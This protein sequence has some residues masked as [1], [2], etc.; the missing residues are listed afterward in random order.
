[1]KRYAA[2]ND[3]LNFCHG[4]GGERKRCAAKT[5][6]TDDLRYSR[7][8]NVPPDGQRPS[9]R[10]RWKQR[11]QKV[12]EPSKGSA[13]VD[14]P[15]W[16]LHDIKMHSKCG[17][18]ALKGATKAERRSEMCKMCNVKR[19]EI[20]SHVLCLASDMWLVWKTCARLPV[21]QR[22]AVLH[23]Q[24]WEEPL[25]WIILP[26]TLLSHYAEVLQWTHYTSFGT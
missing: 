19:T 16:I 7:S 1:M 2:L 22:E 15:R 23:G 18:C 26:V 17:A 20:L 4:G 24:L 8:M 11:V 5:H 21:W 25:A 13:V 9:C 6:L 3:A 10:A 12:E 14:R